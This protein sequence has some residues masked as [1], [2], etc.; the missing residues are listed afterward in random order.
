MLGCI[1][2]NISLRKYIIML[3]EKLYFELFCLNGLRTS[4]LDY[5]KSVWYNLHMQLDNECRQCLYESQLKKVIRMHG[6]NAT[7]E[8][9][10]R[11]VRAL[12]DAAPETSCAPLLMRDIDGIYRSI[13]GKGIDYSEEKNLFNTALLAIEDKILNKILESEEPLKEAIK[14]AMAANYIDFA[15]LSDLNEDSIKEV[16]S[17]A[18]RTVVDE[19]V[20]ALLKEKI[21]KAKTLCYLHDNCGEIVLDKIFIRTAK[22]L[23]PRLNC[24]SVVRGGEIIN[25]ATKRDAE[26]VGLGKF[27]FVVE[28]GAAIPGTYLKECN[29][30]TSAF[31]RNSD[32]V[33]A[34]GLGNLET[35]Y[36]TGN[37][38]FYMFM[39]KCSHIARRFSKN[40]W[41]TALVTDAAEVSEE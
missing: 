9:F 31:I 25:D 24:V 13:F 15:R 33:I 23:N 11:D 28:N 27:S 7:T 8:L 36:G 32:A 37:K 16:I 4:G 1:Y 2:V 30:L 34:K 14:Y 40:L 21:M 29:L 19:E 39:C 5:K 6:E 17:A 41:E 35:L 22:M 18:E 3:S 38:I 26:Q 20:Y 10:R 12:C